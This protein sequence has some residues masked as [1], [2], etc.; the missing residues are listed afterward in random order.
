MQRI[1]FHTLTSRISQYRTK[2]SARFRHLPTICFAA[3][4]ALF[5]YVQ[6]SS[7]YLGDTLDGLVID[8]L[9]RLRNHTQ[10]TFA[11]S[12]DVIIIGL[13]ERIYHSAGMRPSIDPLPRS[14]LAKLLEVLPPTNP[15]AVGLDIIF[16]E[17]TTEATDI[18]LANAI[19]KLPLAL[20][21]GTVSPLV[22][23][24][25]GK[26]RVTI[27]RASEPLFQNA[28]TS[29][30]LVS[31][32]SDESPMKVIREFRITSLKR[33]TGVSWGIQ[34][35]AEAIARLVNPDIKTPV[36]GDFINYYGTTGTVQVVSADDVLNGE[37]KVMEALRGKIILIGEYLLNGKDIHNT[38][39]GF[40]HGV[41]IH[42]TAVSNMLQQNWLRTFRSTRDVLIQAAVLFLLSCMILLARPLQAAALFGSVLAGWAISAYYGLLHGYYIPGALAAIILFII[43]AASNL[44]SYLMARREQKRVL[45]AFGRCVNNHLAAQIANSSF[46]EATAPKVTPITIFFSDIQGY[47]PFCDEHIDNPSFVSRSVNQYFEVIDGVLLQSNATVLHHIGDAV[48]AIWGAPL[49]IDNGPELAVKTALAVQRNLAAHVQ[50]GDIPCF[51]TRIGIHYGTALVGMSGSHGHLD[52]SANGDAVN[53]AARLEQLNKEFGTQILISEEV[54]ASLKDPFHVLRIAEVRLKGKRN[55]INVYTVFDTPVAED[56]RKWWDDAVAAYTAGDHERAARGFSNITDPRLKEAALYYLEQCGKHPQHLW[57]NEKASSLDDHVQ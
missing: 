32:V 11:P 20:P 18:A 27:S 37:P 43:F 56:T 34:T 1:G 44:Y 17:R 42:A 13:D 40:Q 30:G 48:Y 47:T 3:S 14:I 15:V 41:E 12:P 46:E 4:L 54:R 16:K 28:A 50:S 25:T 49:P 5:S 10:P 53:V 6:L 19:A 26:R 7:S 22:N 21:T 45:D 57:T 24:A 51:P 52:Y 23:N 36:A 55:T 8:Q 33:D 29:S 9:F 39:F 35:F 38:P 2:G 31:F